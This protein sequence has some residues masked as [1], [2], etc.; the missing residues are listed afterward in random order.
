M[1]IVYKKPPFWFIT[2]MIFNAK[3]GDVCFAWGDTIYTQK[4]LPEHVIVHEKVH[5]QQMR[6]SKII[7]LYWI[8]MY[9][10]SSKFRLKAEIP[11]YRVQYKFIK[12]KL[13]K[14]QAFIVLNNLAELMSSDT[15]GNMIS[16]NEAKKLICE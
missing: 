3:W 1:Q 16:F 13:N 7:G 9:H 15:Y 6:H 12:N 10:L 2:S 8:A 4:E 11:A 5:L 14:Q